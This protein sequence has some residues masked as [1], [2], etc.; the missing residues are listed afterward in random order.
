MCSLRPEQSWSVIDVLH[1]QARV[2]FQSLVAAGEHEP[3][4]RGSDRHQPPASHGSS[5]TRTGSLPASPPP[6]LAAGGDIA[7]VCNEIQSFRV[8]NT[9]QQWLNYWSIVSNKSHS[10]QEW[11]QLELLVMTRVLGSLDLFLMIVILN[12]VISLNLSGIITQ[13]CLYFREAR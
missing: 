8:T 6:T 3:S 13:Y 5:V 1:Q 9:G 12:K 7:S 11:W 10:S 4:I 2:W